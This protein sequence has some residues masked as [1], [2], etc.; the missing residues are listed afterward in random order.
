MR[1]AKTLVYASTYLLTLHRRD[2]DRT[3]GIGYGAGVPNKCRIRQCSGVGLQR[4]QEFGGGFQAIY[5][6]RRY[7]WRYIAVKSRY[8]ATRSSMPGRAR[9]ALSAVSSLKSV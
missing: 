8:P 5:L 6:W 9:S 2:P 1:L 7:T 3:R 4:K